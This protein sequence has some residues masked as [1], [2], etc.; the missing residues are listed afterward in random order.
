M[1][2]TNFVYINR[3]VVRPYIYIYTCSSKLP[4][5][6]VTKINRVNSEGAQFTFYL[7]SDKLNQ[8]T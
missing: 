3:Y 7:C 8:H 2:V 5:K 4:A 1:S 6:N